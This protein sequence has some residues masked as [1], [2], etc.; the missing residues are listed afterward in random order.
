MA[1]R[2]VKTMPLER[3]K[4]TKGVENSPFSGLGFLAAGRFNVWRH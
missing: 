3:T 4:R 1:S 2:Q